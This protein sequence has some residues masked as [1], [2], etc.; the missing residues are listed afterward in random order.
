MQLAEAC[1]GETQIQTHKV[2]PGYLRFASSG[3]FQKE[4]DSDFIGTNKWCST[5]VQIDWMQDSPD[6]LVRL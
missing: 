2:E 5:T 3:A 4:L 6:F 1:L